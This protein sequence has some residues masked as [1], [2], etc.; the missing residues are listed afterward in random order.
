MSDLILASVTVLLI[1]FFNFRLTP[2][3]KRQLEGCLCRVPSSFYSHVWDVMM[4]TPEG[5]KVAGN[6]IPQQ[7]TLSNMTKSEQTFSLLVEEVRNF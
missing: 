2:R 7:P 5:I 4:R 3:Q 6:V 1:S